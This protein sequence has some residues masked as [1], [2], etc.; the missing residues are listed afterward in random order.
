LFPEK[1]AEDECTALYQKYI[2]AYNKLTD[3]MAKGKG[4]TPEAEQAY[5]EYKEAKGAYERCVREKSGRTRLQPIR[6]AAEIILKGGNSMF[7]PNIFLSLRK[8]LA[9]KQ[10]HAFKGKIYLGSNLYL[11]RN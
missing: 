8:A 2:Q 3:S 7:W 9:T 4:H 6:T 5:E 1:P 11:T 10:S